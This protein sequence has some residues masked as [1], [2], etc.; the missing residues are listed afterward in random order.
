MTLLFLDCNL[1]LLFVA[2]SYSLLHLFV[3]S[4]F[5]PLLSAVLPQ[6]D[7]SLI[8]GIDGSISSIIDASIV[9]KQSPVNIIKRLYELGFEIEEES[10]PHELEIIVQICENCSREEAT[11]MLLDVGWTPPNRDKIIV[12]VT[13]NQGVN[14]DINEE[15]S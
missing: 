11:K 10:I 14:A 6:F 8:S 9:L 3:N 7:Y 2:V 1:S 12:G 5:P 4:G 13:E 15:I